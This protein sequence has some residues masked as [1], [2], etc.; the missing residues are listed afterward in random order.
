MFASCLRYQL[1]ALHHPHSTYSI[2]IMH[3][4]WISYHILNI[5]ILLFIIMLK[6][7][8]PMN[9]FTYCHCFHLFLLKKQPCILLL[10]YCSY[11]YIL[12]LYWAMWYTSHLKYADIPWAI[13]SLT[14]S[15]R[16]DWDRTFFHVG[17]L[18]EVRFF[19]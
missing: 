2:Y 6:A 3:S 1:L 12:K 16:N 17:L 10:F 4:H 13:H 7:S 19:M 15:T 11:E 14:H 18:V 5:A 8:G 9:L